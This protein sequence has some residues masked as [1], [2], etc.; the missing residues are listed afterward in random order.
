MNMN[1]K[2]T[3]SLL[4]IAALFWMAIPNLTAHAGT[5]YTGGL[6]DGLALKTGTTITSPSATS[7]TQTTDN[8]V[9]TNYAVS[10]NLVWYTFT[11]PQDISAVIVNKTGSGVATVEFYDAG[12]K[13]ISSYTPVGNDGVESLPSKLM[14]VSTA[15]LKSSN[16]ASMNVL[17]WNV[18]ATPS[19]A[20][21]VPAVSWIYGGDKVVN[22]SWNTTGAK[23][24]NVKRSTT[25]SGPFTALA[26]GVSGTAYTDKTVVNGTQ[27][28]YV[29]SAVNEAGESENSAVKTIKPL[30]TRYTGG[31]L[32]G[33]ELKIGTSYTSQTAASLNMSDNNTATYYTISTNLVR[34]TFSAPQDIS[35]V[36]VNKSSNGTAMVE[37]YDDGD[38]LISSYSLVGNDGIESLP[39]TLSNVSTVILKS[40]NGAAM[41]VMEWNVFTTPSAAPSSPAISWI[42]GGDKTVNLTWNTTGAKAYNVK[43]STSASGP[44][45]TVAASV[46]GTAYTDTTVVNGTQYYYVISAVNETGES[47][48]SVAATIKPLATRYTGGLLDGLELKIGTS[49]TSQT[50]ASLNMSDNNTATYYTISTNLVRHTFSA[51]KD[52]SAVLVNKSSNGAAMVE[53]F[54]AGDN[55]ISSYNLVGNDGI[56]SLPSPLKNVSTVILKSSNGAAMHVMEWNVFTTPSAAPSYPAISWI[57]GGDKVVNLAWNTSGAKVYNVKRSLSSTGPF[58]T[59]ATGISGTAYS[60]NT[61]VNDTQYYYVISGVNEAGESA[62][63]IPV[64]TKPQATKY[65]K[66]LLTGLELNVGTELTNKTGKTRDTTDNNVATAAG[67]TTNMTWH[68]FSAPKNITSVIVNK[69]GAP[70]RV[71]FYNADNQ[72][73]SV[74]NPISNDVV[75]TLL[76]AVNNVT[77]VALKSATGASMNVLEWNVFG[78]GPDPVVT[79]AAPTNLAGIAGNNQA[80]LSW[81][82][83]TGATSY[84]VKRSDTAGGPYTVVSSTGTTTS[85]TDTSVVNGSTYYYVVTASNA[86]GESAASNEIAVTPNAPAVSPAAPT[87]LTGNASNNQAS[88]SW[89]ASSGTT[90]YIVKRSN[91][92]G[93]PYAVIGSTGTVTSFTDTNVVNGLTYYY[94]V[95]ASNAVGESAASNEAAVVIPNSPVSLPAAPTNLVG[96]AGNNQVSLSWTASTGAASYT[97]KRSGTAGG[98]Y[99]VVGSAVTATSFTDTTVVNGSTYYYVVTASN[100]NGESA[101]SNEAAVSVN[102]ESPQ[103]PYPTNL[104]AAAGNQQVSLTWTAAKG[105]S[106]YIV[107]RSTAINGAYT[108]IALM[109]TGTSYTDTTVSNGTTYYYTVSAIIGTSESN[110]SNSAF[111]TPAAPTQNSRALLE[112]TMVSGAR[113]EYDL[114]LDE[115]NTFM[116]WYNNRASG[117]GPAVYAMNKTY[118]KGPYTTRTDYIA[119]DKIQSFEVNEYSK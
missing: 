27:Y 49:Y 41:H 37:F 53:F 18:F 98:P 96:N 56:E 66:G 79:P 45:A 63:S 93:G 113:F 12:N 28:Y 48:D 72:L 44:Y 26:A 9:S 117:T 85:F 2:K 86:V 4:L 8:N 42:Y 87:N 58:A 111:A 22:L 99:T 118:N 73:V 108:Q 14:N 80:S 100:A 16:G 30:A 40:S 74:Y 3:C 6:L 94:V 33:L 31:L 36:L 88:L 35:A 29:I 68:T 67:F 116:S 10:N 112:I 15:I 76:P 52:I 92:A 84:T 47:A 69:T 50:A 83:S 102:S 61:V 77:T 38:N 25:S 11:D 17:E 91:T 39:S 19:A 1:F 59:V 82:A 95:T 32:D 105:A 55:L 103:L 109:V 46:N 62:N 89:T 97:V 75:E 104:T 5:K 43:R 54:D 90:N 21:A 70:A 65:T 110:N 119:F 64:S 101:K 107:K 23:A 34:H 78:T 81:A 114:S 106:G 20:P 24:Y 60:D 57:Y 7:V 115:L 13:L 71:E 51:P